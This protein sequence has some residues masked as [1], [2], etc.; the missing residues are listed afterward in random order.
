VNWKHR[1]L[2]IAVIAGVSTLPAPGD[3]IDDL[4]AETLGSAATRSEAAGRLVK[5]AKKLPDAPEAQRR[6]CEKAYAF[7]ILAPSGHPAAMA[8][9]DILDK[10]APARAAE[11]AAK[12]LEVARLRY[13]RSDRK[14]R[15]ATGQAYVTLLLARG[16]ADRKA[17]QWAHAVMHYRQAYSVAKALNLPRKKAIYD[18]AT[19]TAARAATLERVKRLKAAVAEDPDNAENRRA[20]ILACL[21]DLDRPE[22]A[23]EYLNDKV[24]EPLRANAALAAKPAAELADEDFLTLGQWYQTLANGT[25]LKF[26]RVRM[27]CRARDNLKFY[28]EVHTKADARRLEAKSELDKVQGMLAA[29]APARIAPAHDLAKGLVLRYTFDKRQPG[30]V[31][32]KSPQ[33]NHGKFRGARWTAKGHKGGAAAFDG[34]GAI[35]VPAS[36]VETR[37][38]WTLAAWIRPSRLRQN[39]I[40]IYTKS[41]GCAF[42]VAG[43]NDRRGDR[44]MGLFEQVLWLDSGY[45]FP[46]AGRWYH[47]VMTRGTKTTRFYVNGTATPK[48][49]SATPNP[50]KRGRGASI[51]SGGARTFH[52]AVD[53]VMIWNRQLTAQEVKVLY[54]LTGGT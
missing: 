24:A 19:A 30:L 21:V 26:A 20:L 49:F 18:R 50:G 52:G 15:P 34:A 27:L 33:K 39:G 46:A 10:V 7:G 25:M 37:D 3:A 31:Y 22:T 13:L 2:C 12:R 43:G 4:I 11:W 29:L 5:T 1:L 28:L 44:L 14:T 9:L 8:A 6:L 42:A 54:T 48:T 17:G 47:V 32:D 51:S 36:P 40:V 45:A 35:T 41:W 16:E 23:A 38:N 53:D